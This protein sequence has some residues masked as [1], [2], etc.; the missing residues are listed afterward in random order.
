MTLAFMSPTGGAVLLV[1]AVAAIMMIVYAIMQGMQGKMANT[2]EQ[3]LVR[4]VKLTM[5]PEKADELAK[6]LST[7][8]NDVKE[9]RLGGLETASCYVEDVNG[10]GPT[11]VEIVVRKI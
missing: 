11:F 5:V 8:S 3:D 6:Q 10:N 1:V 7:A 2:S 9:K 4:R